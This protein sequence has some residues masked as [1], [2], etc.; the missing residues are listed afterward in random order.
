VTEEALARTNQT[1]QPPPLTLP[2]ELELGGV[3]NHQ[4][5]LQLG[6]PPRCLADMRAENPLGRHFLIAEEAIGPLQSGVIQ[7]FGKT[8]SRILSQPLSEGTETPIQ[9]AVTQLGVV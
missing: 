1:P 7:R 5:L 9:S 4:Y 2:A 6:R 3:V 8:L